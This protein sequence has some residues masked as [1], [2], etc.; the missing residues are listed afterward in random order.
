[1]CGENFGCG[2][3]LVMVVFYLLVNCV[4][5]RCFIVVI[6]IDVLIL[7][8]GD[9]ICYILWWVEIY[10]GDLYCDVIFGGYVVDW[11]YY[12]LFYGMGVKV[13]DDFVEIYGG[14]YINCCFVCYLK[15]WYV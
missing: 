5:V 11:F 14:F 4:F 2:D 1:M 15:V 13:I 3:F 12:V 7:Y 9:C 6:V 8:F 10:I